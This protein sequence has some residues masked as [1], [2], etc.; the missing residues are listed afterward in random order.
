MR[1]LILSDLHA[2]WEALHAVLDDAAREGYD[3]ILCCGDLVGYGADP[4]LVVE[5][6]QTRVFQVIRGNHDKACAGLEDLEWFTPVAR[7]SALW[8]RETLKPEN[9][10]YLRR[11]RKGPL[12]LDGF[13]LVHGS[14]LD[15]DEYLITLNDVAEV[16]PYLEGALIFFGHTHLQGGFSAQRNRIRRIESA[17]GAAAP[18]KATRNTL[19]PRSVVRE[20]PEKPRMI[21]EDSTLTLEPDAS[22]LINPGSVGQPR[23]GDPRAAYA[24]YTPEQRMVRYRRVVY[25][26]AAAQN[27]IVSA[28]LPETLAERLATGS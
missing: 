3:R 21:F 4:N 19:P 28:G 5:W 12:A 1:Y 27:K 9:A 11:L 10:D 25:D 2:N 24:I 23:D 15:E 7:V 16:L 14:P 26:I 13:D 18:F 22:Y 20:F 17:Q 8:T 6:V